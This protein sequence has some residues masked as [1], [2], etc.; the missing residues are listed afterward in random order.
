MPGEKRG[1]R[2][3]FPVHQH[4]DKGHD[5]NDRKRPFRSYIYNQSVDQDGRTRRLLSFAEAHSYASFGENS[6]ARRP[7]GRS[8]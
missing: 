6:P 1:R 3:P 7:R 8:S 4:A 2:S 5:K